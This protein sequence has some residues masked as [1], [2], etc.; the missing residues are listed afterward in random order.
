MEVPAAPG[1]SQ[2]VLVG[3]LAWDW[4]TQVTAQ[5]Q[6]AAL[7]ASHPWFSSDCHLLQIIGNGR[8]PGDALGMRTPSPG[9][10]LA[11]AAQ[12]GTLG[13]ARPTGEQWFKDVGVTDSRVWRLG[14]PSLQIQP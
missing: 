13:L 11:S 9:S 5:F 8:G 1:Q 14:N 2:A 4:L 3:A 10:R 6:H 7:K 12:D